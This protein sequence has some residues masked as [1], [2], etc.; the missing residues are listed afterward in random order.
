M[1]YVLYVY[2][3]AGCAAIWAAIWSLGGTRARLVL[4]L[5]AYALHPRYVAPRRSRGRL[6]RGHPDHRDREYVNWKAFLPPARDHD[7]TDPAP[8]RTPAI[9]GLGEVPTVII[10]AYVPHLVR[11]DLEQP[12][13][14]GWGDLLADMNTEEREIYSAELVEVYEDTKGIE[15]PFL[16][17]LDEVIARFTAAN[18]AG[19]RRDA[20]VLVGIGANLASRHGGHDRWST[21][22]FPLYESVAEPALV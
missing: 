10:P 13:A 3:S 9:A 18:D 8:A 17:G 5:G 2:E 15:R 11:A 6:R 12:G 22:Q 1:D 14:E 19:E 7:W 20:A 21:G 4:S 16:E